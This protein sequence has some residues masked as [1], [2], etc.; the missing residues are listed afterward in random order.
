MR[1]VAAAAL[2]TR[3]A[4]ATHAGVGSGCGLLLVHAA[5]EPPWHV[6]CPAKLLTPPLPAPCK[7][8]KCAKHAQAHTHR[9]A[10]TQ[11]HTHRR[12]QRRTFC[13]S[14]CAVRKSTAAGT[15]P[16]LKRSALQDCLWL[17]PSSASC[18]RE[19]SCTWR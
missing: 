7:T 18:S 3:R 4:R 10:H 19:P 8:H 5:H 14:C 6:R 2:S 13:F 9:Q 17:K 12:T 1:L 15:S 11:A 16:P